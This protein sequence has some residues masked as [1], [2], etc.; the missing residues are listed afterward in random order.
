MTNLNEATRYIEKQEIQESIKEEFHSN[1]LEVDVKAEMY[2]NITYIY[3]KEKKKKKKIRSLH[4]T[5]TFFALFLGH[6]YFFCS[7]KNVPLDYVKVIAIS[8]GYRNS[9]RIK[10][11]GK[12]LRSLIKLLWIN[13]QGTLHAN[14]I[15]QPRVYQPTNPVVR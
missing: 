9:K 5:P 2:N 8:L 7:K 4:T 12:D 15:S 14:D 6:K 3:V 11:M 1:A 13:Q 10:L